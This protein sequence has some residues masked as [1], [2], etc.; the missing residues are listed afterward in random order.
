MNKSI[1][2]L[3]C[4]ALAPLNF[5]HAGDRSITLKNG[6]NTASNF[7]PEEADGA[8]SMSMLTA[9]EADAAK[10]IS[11]SVP[12]ANPNNKAANHDGRMHPTI[13]NDPNQ[14]H[15]LLPHNQTLLHVD[16]SSV[17]GQASPFFVEG[18]NFAVGILGNAQVLNS[19]EGMPASNWFGDSTDSTFVLANGSVQIVFPQDVQATSLL[20]TT[21]DKEK[22]SAFSDD[23]GIATISVALL[24]AN[25]TM[26]STSLIHLSDGVK[27]LD[28][29]SDVGFRSVILSSA[30]RSWMFSNLTYETEASEMK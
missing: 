12:S 24:D 21:G 28:I 11:M 13:T 3:A 14:F 9:D 26:I 4:V 15:Q 8:K 30:L 18:N 17:S 27:E 7:T 19:Y 6:S 20:T 25:G 1:V 5:A 10:G 16:L 2:I 22:L 23:Q 29:P